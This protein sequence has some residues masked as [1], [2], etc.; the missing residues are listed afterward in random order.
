MPRGDGTGPMG[1]GPKTGRAYG[2][3]AGD[4]MPGFMNPISGF[5]MGARFGR[6]R[7]A[8]FR[9]GGWRNMF[10]ATGLSG[11][12]R[13]AM[14]WPEFGGGFYGTP[15]TPEMNRERQTQALRD[16]A[17]FLEEQLNAVRK[18]MEE[19]SAQDETEK[20]K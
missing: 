17:G 12:Q 20:E 16:Q 15:T 3:R 8:G 18:R 7:G 19:L 9:G 13:A 1:F 4:G 10:Y 6:G 11:R 5:G 14:G 2:Y